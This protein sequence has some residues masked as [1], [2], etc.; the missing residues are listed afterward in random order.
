MKNSKKAAVIDKSGL[1]RK[2]TKTNS[3][4]LKLIF[5]GFRAG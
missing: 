3:A 2:D 5:A 1:L 4:I